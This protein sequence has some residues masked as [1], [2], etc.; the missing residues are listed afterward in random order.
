MGRKYIYTVIL[1]AL[2]K[3]TAAQQPD[4]DSLSQMV[5][6]TKNDTLL[7]IRYND[8]AWAYSERN[9]DCALFYAENETKLYR[10]YWRYHIKY[11][12]T[13]VSRITFQYVVYKEMHAC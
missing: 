11:Q 1:I 3:Y 7:L 10:N 13:D 12:A 8:L 2:V 9:P 6:I 4:I 5:R